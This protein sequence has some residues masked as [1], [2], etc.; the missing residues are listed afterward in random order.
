MR[1]DIWHWSSCGD[2]CVGQ[3]RGWSSAAVCR[4]VNWTRQFLW[5][6]MTQFCFCSRLKTEQAVARGTTNPAPCCHLANDTDLLTPVL[7]AMAGDNKQI[8]LWPADPFTELTQNVIRSSH[9]HSTHLPWKFHANRSSRFLV[10]LLTK[11]QRKKEIA[12]KQ[13]PVWVTTQWSLRRQ[14]K[15]ARSSRL[16]GKDKC[17]Y[18]TEMNWTELNWI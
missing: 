1:A 4:R 17:P 7:W 3:H 11:K 6:A 2:V 15:T 14:L 16:L 8:D 12:Q 5:S 10:M 13:Y 9:G 18:W